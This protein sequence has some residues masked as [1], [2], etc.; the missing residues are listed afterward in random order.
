MPQKTGLQN[1]E[2]IIKCEPDQATSPN[3]LN[4]VMSNRLSLSLQTKSKSFLRVK[5]KSALYKGLG[6]IDFGSTLT[7]TKW[8]LILRKSTNSNLIFQIHIVPS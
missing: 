7:N 6:C 8:S 2:R 4:D 5:L 3:L 1:T